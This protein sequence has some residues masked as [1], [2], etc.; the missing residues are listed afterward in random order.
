[1]WPGTYSCLAAA[2]EKIGIIV[3]G[4]RGRK[5]CFLVGGLISS[6][7]WGLPLHLEPWWVRQDEEWGDQVDAGHL[8]LQGRSISNLEPSKFS[9]LFF[10][11]LINWITQLCPEWKLELYKSLPSCYL[12]PWTLPFDHPV[13]L[14]IMHFL[15]F[16]KTSKAP[17]E[18]CRRSQLIQSQALRPSSS[19]ITYTNWQWY[20]SF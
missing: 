18:Y 14:E 8:L 12:E 1:M 3:V 4:G 6:K 17:E 9:N 15:H 13:P 19:S 11:S 16:Y 20:S 10:A 5:V 7:A 2:A